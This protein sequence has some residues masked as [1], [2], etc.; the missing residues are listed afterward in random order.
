MTT[1]TS[2][3]PN[4]EVLSVWRCRDLGTPHRWAYL[5][6]ALQKYRCQ[7]CFGTVTKT[8]LKAETD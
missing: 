5:G 8:R 4:E 2:Q 1:Q 3:V 7:E 6:K